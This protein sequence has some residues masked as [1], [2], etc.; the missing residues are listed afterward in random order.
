[1][2]QQQQQ[3][4]DDQMRWKRNF[5]IAYM[6]CLAHSRCITVLTRNRWGVQALGTPCAWGAAIMC[7]WGFA[8]RDPLLW[9]WAAIWCIAWVKR[10]QQAVKLP[11][12]GARIHSW[13]DG[14]PHE[15]VKLTK[16]DEEKAKRI[17]EPLWTA[18]IGG[19]LMWFYMEVLH[20]PPHG[21]PYFLILGSLTISVVEGIK[22]TIGERRRQSMLDARIEQENVMRDFRDRYG[23]Q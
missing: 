9:A 14:F 21:L 23:D 20:R 10:K 3:Q 22:K 5:N 6:L 7:V 13:Y 15:S 12:E 16:G 4:Q 18:C 11:K 17:V 1:M 19:T 8:S 2:Q